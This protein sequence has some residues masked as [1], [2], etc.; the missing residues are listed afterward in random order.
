M[1]DP[2]I[3]YSSTENICDIDAAAFDSQSTLIAWC[4]NTGGNRWAEKERDI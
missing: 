4:E 2:Q 1:E 3:L